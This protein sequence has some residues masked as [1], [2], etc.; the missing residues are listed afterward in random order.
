MRD[1]HMIGFEDISHGASLAGRVICMITNGHV[2]AISESGIFNASLWYSDGP[3][4]FG[5]G[6]EGM[7]GIWCSGSNLYC[8]PFSM[9]GMNAL[10]W[11]LQ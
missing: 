2:K 10:Q 6:V 8:V 1:G 4:Y 5:A 7:S 3:N 11:S 9:R